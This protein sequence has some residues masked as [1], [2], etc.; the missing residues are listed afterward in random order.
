MR[1][2][3]TGP[4][5]PMLYNRIEFFDMCVAGALSYLRALWPDEMRRVHVD[6]GGLPVGA[7]GPDGVHRWRTDPRTGRVVLYRVAIWRLA[8]LH[9]NDAWHR[10]SYIESCVFRAVAEVLGKDPWEIGP[11]R[12]RHF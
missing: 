7:P 3:V 9:K 10:R 11:E 2:A 5:L 1:S 4:H 8:I 12:F 6:V